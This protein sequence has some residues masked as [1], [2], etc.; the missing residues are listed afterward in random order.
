[1]EKD[2]RRNLITLNPP[3]RVAAVEPALDL[4][5]NLPRIEERV[6]KVWRDKDLS[7][8]LQAARAGSEKWVFYEGPPTANGRPGVHHVW[9][10][11][12]KDLYPRFQT[13]RGKYVP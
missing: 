8:R 12:F 3:E 2:N 1:M 13:M 11:A 9:A 5:F 4:E 6:L 7:A 10:R